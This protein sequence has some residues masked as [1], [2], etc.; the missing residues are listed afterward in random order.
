MSRRWW[1]V[2]GKSVHAT[3]FLTIVAREVPDILKPAYGFGGLSLSQ[4]CQPYV[5]TWLRTR[6]NVADLVHQ[7]NVFVLKTNMGVEL[8]GGSGAAP[9]GLVQADVGSLDGRVAAFNYYRN[10]LGTFVLDK[11]SEDFANVAAPI[12]GLDRIQAQAFEFVVAMAGQPM[13]KFAGIQPSGLNASSEGEIRVFYDS[14]HA[15]Q[16]DH[17]RDPLQTVIDFIQL[18]AFGDIDES[19]RFSFEP[20]W[21]MSEKEI[22]DIRKVEADTDNVYI[23]AGVLSPQDVRTRVAADLDSGYHGL[24]ADDLPDLEEEEG[25]GL[26]PDGKSGESALDRLFDAAAFDAEWEENS[27]PRADNGQ[28]GSS[29][30]GGASKAEAGSSKSAT[31]TPASDLYAEHAKNAPKTEEARISRGAEIAAEYGATE[32]VAQARE[33][34]R[35]GTPTNASVSVGGHVQ[36]N[37]KYTDE[38]KALH[39]KILDEIFT[40]EAIMA[41]D[42][43]EGQRPVMTVLG[44]RGGSGKSWLTG[45]D[46][47]VDSSKSLVIDADHFKGQLPEYEGW[48]AGLLHEES[49]HLV[50]LAAKRSAELGINVVFDAT[51]KSA[52]SAKDRIAQFEQAGYDIHGHYMFASPETATSRAVGRFVRGGE[53]GRFVPPEVVMGNT[54]NEKNFDEAI[55]LFKKWSIHDNNGS[56]GGA[57]RHVASGVN[58]G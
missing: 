56:S 5:D 21:A 45:K 4:L 33:R 40:K 50:D 44:G 23:D 26:K 46:G 39:D 11:D 43:E 58:D 27:H 14:I 38:R 54:D 30:S 15:A 9:G 20:L 16:E 6:G 57:P 55:P 49:N 28:F 25:A 29:G 36:P 1:F 2:M 52:K 31:S 41:S 7:F 35:A 48:N 42:P 47:P 37:G 13:V 34:M 10:N 12:T 24:D 51:L 18:D 53:K 17:I 22:A 32:R 3:R 8:P 19:I